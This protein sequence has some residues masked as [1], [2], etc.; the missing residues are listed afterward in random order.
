MTMMR[1][2]GP[3]SKRGQGA[4]TT[5]E[6]QPREALPDRPAASPRHTFAKRALSI[7]WSGDEAVVMQD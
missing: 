1:D 6:K 4:G 3:R 7:S 2:A 5:I